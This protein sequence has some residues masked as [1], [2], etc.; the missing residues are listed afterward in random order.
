MQSFSQAVNEILDQI[1]RP[2]DTSSMRDRVRGWV[3]EEL[4]NVAGDFDHPGLLTKSEHL[5]DEPFGVTSQEFDTFT[6]A[7][8]DLLKLYKVEILDPTNSPP[9]LRRVSILSYA[10]FRRK[11]LASSSNSTTRADKG[12]PGRPSSIAFD[13]VSSVNLAGLPSPVSWE[14]RADIT[15]AAGL[16]VSLYG[17]PD[18]THQRFFM[19]E[20]GSGLTTTPEALGGADAMRDP[21]TFSKSDISGGRITLSD[22]TTDRAVIEPT[23]MHSFVTKFMLH[24]YRDRVDYRLFVSYK[25]RPP[26]MRLDGDVPSGMRYEAWQIIKE[27]ALSTALRFVRND[28]EQQKAEKRA[29][30][31]RGALSTKLREEQIEDAAWT[32]AQPESQEAITELD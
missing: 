16:T 25:R 31:L 1:N 5:L 28:G 24:P 11:F 6:R 26:L 2:G 30:E 23:E 17:Y 15:E 7:P 8:A 29:N 13:R 18:S 9:R 20:N 32:W 4:I 10:D 12:S 21:V 14:V 27:A 19:L 3:N 22:G